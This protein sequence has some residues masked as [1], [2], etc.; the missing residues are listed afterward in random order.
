MISGCYK[1]EKNNIVTYLSSHKNCKTHA[2][3]DELQALL[4]KQ[5]NLHTNDKRLNVLTKKNNTVLQQLVGKNVFVNN[6]INKLHVQDCIA[7]LCGKT[8]PHIII[9]DFKCINEYTS[10]HNAFAHKLPHTQ[11]ITIQACTKHSTAL[12]T[13]VHTHNLQKNDTFMALQHY[14]L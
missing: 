2:I 1:S 10:I 3:A 12:K 4:I 9:S 7:T 6:L 13:F 11:I 14:K 5:Y 8:P